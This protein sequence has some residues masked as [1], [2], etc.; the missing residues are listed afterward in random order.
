MGNYND[1]EIPSYPYWK[2]SLVQLQRQVIHRTK[3]TA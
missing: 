1:H 3:L 2:S